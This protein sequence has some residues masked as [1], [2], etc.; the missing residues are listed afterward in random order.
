MFSYPPV[1]KRM[2]LHNLQDKA[3]RMTLGFV[4][5]KFV[6][7]DQKASS[8]EIHLLNQIKSSFVI[9]NNHPVPLCLLIH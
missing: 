8:Q 4:L 1:C 3:P 9:H 5:M 6:P 2:D 7:P